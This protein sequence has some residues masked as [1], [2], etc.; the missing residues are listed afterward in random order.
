M[1]S[2]GPLGLPT[3]PFEPK[4]VARR[5][6]PRTELQSH[7]RIDALPL[8]LVA[9]AASQTMTVGVSL[10]LFSSALNA[11]RLGEL[12]KWH[13]TLDPVI[14]L[15]PLRRPISCQLHLYGLRQ[16]NGTRPPGH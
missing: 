2:C 13:A 5:Q 1:W 14:S 4:E 6:G 15:G 8:T 12:C 3:F 9:D 16:S 10:Y 11:G 7:A